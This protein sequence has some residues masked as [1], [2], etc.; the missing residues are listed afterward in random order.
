[1][2]VTLAK[3]GSKLT[4]SQTD[5]NSPSGLFFSCVR[6]TVRNATRRKYTSPSGGIRSGIA[7]LWIRADSR[8]AMISRST[9]RPM[10]FSSR[11]S[12]PR[13]LHRFL[14]HRQ[15]EADAGPSYS[16]QQQLGLK[17]E[18]MNAPVDA[19]A[20]RPRRQTLRELAEIRPSRP[21]PGSTGYEFKNTSIVFLSGL[22]PMRRLMTSTSTKVTRRPELFRQCRKDGGPSGR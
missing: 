7:R 17:L 18:S 19:L 12:V 8:A 14:R 21:A 13:M 4:P 9:G 16:M 2:C 6:F 11:D 20:D 5:P 22:R 3:G 10:S 1:M 15:G